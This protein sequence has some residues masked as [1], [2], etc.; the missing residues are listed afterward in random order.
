MIGLSPSSLGSVQLTTAEPDAALAPMFVGAVG[1]DFGCGV[2]ALDWAE[3]APLPFGLD[4]C[5]VNV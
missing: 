3:T 4:A 5:T 1:A 2:T